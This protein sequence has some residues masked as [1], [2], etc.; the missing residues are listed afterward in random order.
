MFGQLLDAL[1][2]VREVFRQLSLGNLIDVR[3]NRTREVSQ[4]IGLGM[5]LHRVERF[6]GLRRWPVQFER[7]LGDFPLSRSFKPWRAR[8]LRP[9]A[10]RW[11]HYDDAGKAEK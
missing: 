5:K 10:D 3:R 7:V 11:G 9:R 1:E 6:P 2:F 4:F 8:A